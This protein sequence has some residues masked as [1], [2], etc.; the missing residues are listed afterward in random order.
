MN[1]N[2]LLSTILAGTISFAQP[3]KDFT[4][5]PIMVNSNGVLDPRPIRANIPTK[6]VI[7]YEHVREA[8]VVWSKRIWRVIDLREKFNHPLYY[9]LD[10][11]EAGIWKTNPNAWSLWTI[12]RAHVL[13][14]DLTLYSTYHPD[15]EQW[16][17]GD[18][19]QYPITSN[20]PGG[21]Y[22][23]NKEF[24]EKLYPYLGYVPLDPFAVPLKSNLF[25]TED[26]V[27]CYEDPSGTRAPGEYHGEYIGEPGY[28]CEA[29]YAVEDTVWYTSKD[30]V[31][32]K[33]KEDHFFDKEQSRKRVRIIGIA[34]CIYSRDKD[35]NITGTEELFWLYFPECRYVFQNFYLQ[36][37]DNDS[38]RMS[39]DD[40]FWKRMFQSY[41]VKES[42]I[43]NRDVDSYKSGLDAL[44]ESERIKDKLYT[45]EEELWSY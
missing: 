29:Q 1:I 26:S 42:S 33:I 14:G 4:K 38:H 23:N 17:D 19:F 22:Y 20:V 30:I 27:I 43:Y 36:S 34:P 3:R 9:P 6:K 2:L 45:F 39:Y 5:G 25:P 21:N 24:R 8:D 40:L 37:R 31:Q 28:L 7:P 12:I 41:V 10:E 18:G 32:Y 11:I 16:N 35:G 13:T 44:L 15:W